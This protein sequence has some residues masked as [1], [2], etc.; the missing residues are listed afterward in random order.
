MHRRAWGCAQPA[1]AR[2]KISTIGAGSKKVE[3]RIRF[4]SVNLISRENAVATESVWNYNNSVDLDASLCGKRNVFA[5]NLFHSIFS[6]HAPISQKF[7][8][9]SQEYNICFHLV[10]NKPGLW[11]CFSLKFH[12]RSENCFPR[13]KA[14]RFFA[15]C[16]AVEWNTTCAPRSNFLLPSAAVDLRPDNKALWLIR[17]PQTL[18]GRARH[19]SLFGW[20]AGRLCRHKG[21]SVL[22]RYCS[23]EGKSSAHAAVQPGSNEINQVC[24]CGVSL[25]KTLDNETLNWSH[26]RRRP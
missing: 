10:Y 12:S 6:S 5:I 9:T 15:T 8:T 18:V 13:S 1:R 24:K 19:L 2:C 25:D 3:Y 20:T 11:N 22:T 14:L 16:F 26:L 17:R 23:A 4:T 7:L 21:S